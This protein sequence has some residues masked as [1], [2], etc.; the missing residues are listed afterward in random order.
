MRAL[1]G[2]SRAEFL[3]FGGAK[4]FSKHPSAETEISL[5]LPT[6]LRQFLELFQFWQRGG[7]KLLVKMTFLAGAEFFNLRAFFNIFCK[8]STPEFTSQI[9]QENIN[10][11]LDGAYLADFGIDITA[12]L[13]R[14]SVE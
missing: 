12:A 7:A 13:T 8:I 11:P 4:H 5:K 1:M 6:K 10:K 2:S 3:D 9:C 14:E